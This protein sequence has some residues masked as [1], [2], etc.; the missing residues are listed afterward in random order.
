M[1][2]QAKRAAAK[3]EALQQPMV[4]DAQGSA[5]FSIWGPKP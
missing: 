3:K 2:L 4:E 5:F 1:F